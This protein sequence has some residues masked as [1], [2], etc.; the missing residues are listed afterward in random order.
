MYFKAMR[1]ASIIMVKHSDGVA[2]ATIATGE[3]LLRP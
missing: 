1:H 2:G 3:S